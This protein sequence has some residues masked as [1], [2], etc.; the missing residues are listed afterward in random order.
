MQ[1]LWCDSSRFEDPQFPKN[2]EEGDNP[3]SVMHLGW[4][5]RIMAGHYNGLAS[6]YRTDF[7]IGSGAEAAKAITLSSDQFNRDLRNR[8]VKA[9]VARSRWDLRYAMEKPH[10]FNEIDLCTWFTDWARRDGYGKLDNNRIDQVK[11]PRFPD[12]KPSHLRPVDG[13][14]TFGATI[15]HEV[16]MPGF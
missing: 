11:D 4:G 6:C 3:L 1:A 8:D 2:R 13:L 10:L 9:G 7:E 12:G 16:G 15:L 14:K 5:G